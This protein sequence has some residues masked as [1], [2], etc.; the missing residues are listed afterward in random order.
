MGRREP[1]SRH[2]FGKQTDKTPLRGFD[3]KKTRRRRHVLRHERVHAIRHA[4]TPALGTRLLRRVFRVQD[5]RDERRNMQ[6]T[7]SVQVRRQ[8]QG[9][10]HH[11]QETNDVWKRR[12]HERRPLHSHPDAR[13]LATDLFRQS[14]QGQTRLTTHTINIKISVAIHPYVYGYFP[15]SIVFFFGFSEF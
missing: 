9:R 3:R 13:F 1:H 4:T 2:M 8:K 6:T 11:R 15:R 12:R 14:R 7:E 10:R 5:G